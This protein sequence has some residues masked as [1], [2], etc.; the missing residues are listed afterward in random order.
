MLSTHNIIRFP[1]DMK[2]LLQWLSWN[3]SD[4]TG[5]R[6]DL[7]TLGLLSFGVL[8]AGWGE[9]TESP[10]EPGVFSCRAVRGVAG[11][12]LG[13]TSKDPALPSELFECQPDQKK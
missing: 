11:D 3:T 1:M 10:S 7:T 6:V 12:V 13:G 8:L 9:E 4:D 5:L 2:W